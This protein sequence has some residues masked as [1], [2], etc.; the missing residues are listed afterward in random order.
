MRMSE[1]FPL[2]SLTFDEE[3]ALQSQ[4]E[5]D[6]LIEQATESPSATDAI[7]LAHGF[8]NDVG[9]A[10]MWYDMFL[11]TFRS[12][13]TRPE[14]E[15]I[16][17]R[18]FVVAGVYWPSKPFKET[19]TETTRGLQDKS[20][21]MAD[22]KKQLQDFKKHDANAA[23]RLKL[24]KAIRLLPKLEGNPKAQD[25]FVALV[26]S[27]LDN[28]PADKTEGLAQI[29]TRSGSELLARLG[30]GAPEGTR[31]IGGWFSGIA[32]SVGQFLNLTTWYIMKDR[33]GVVGSTGVAATVRSLN[34]ACPDLRIHLVGHS[35]GGRLMA[36]CAKALSEPPPLQV[37]SLTLLE[38][39]FSHFGFSDDNGHG[40]S[41]FFRDVVVKQVVKGPFLSTFSKEDTVVGNAYAIMSRLACDNTREIGDA[42][43][44][45][46]GIGRN[47]PQKTKEV[48]NF[49]FNKPGSAYTY[50]PGVINNLD[51]SGGFIKEHGDVMND[52][53]TYAFASAVA[54]TR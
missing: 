41:G 17:A 36:S 29:R 40:A 54:Q 37:D 1:G 2:F 30:A 48:A 31:G 25:D 24:D 46:G 22:A 10:T 23:Q 4:D 14:F 34:E 51:G 45:F 27:L 15:D 52:A 7:F 49:P 44:E 43:D 33:S 53:V 8:R 12:H 42:S 19:F 26:L 5:L 32:G 6:A 50:K 20:R 13:F 11:N 28:S 9:D 21:M 38:A 39:A 47:G 35:L 18:R 16:A 3:G